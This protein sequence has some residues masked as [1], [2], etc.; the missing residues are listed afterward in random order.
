LNRRA[1][2]AAALA[3]GAGGCSSPGVK[4]DAPYVSTPYEVVEEMLRLAAVRPD[5]LLY[6][7]GCGD[8]RI[9]IEAARRYG[10]RG[11]GVDIDPARI[12][13]AN[14]AAARAGVQNRVRFVVQDFFE[15]DLSPATVVALYLYSELNARLKPKFLAELRPGGR[16]VSHEYGIGDWLPAR[17]TQVEVQGSHRFVH[18]WVVPAR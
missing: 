2:L 17:T 6:D 18:L 15:T 12:A 8:G 14:A 9:V 13:E 1:F 4:L 11:V 3:L 10:A 7:L 16:I 5:D